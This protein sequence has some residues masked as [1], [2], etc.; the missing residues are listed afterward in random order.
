MTEPTKERDAVS[1]WNE[2]QQRI[3]QFVFETQKELG[4]ELNIKRGILAG[5]R[6]MNQEHQATLEKAQRQLAA[7]RAGLEKISKVMLGIDAKQRSDLRKEIAREALRDSL[8][9]K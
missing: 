8:G 3:D 6:W 7:A 1:W 2:N 5:L 9:E 4:A